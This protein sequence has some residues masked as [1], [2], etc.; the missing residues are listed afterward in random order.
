[1]ADPGRPRGS[2]LN[3]PVYP[4]LPIDR[5]PGLILTVQTWRLFRLEAAPFTEWSWA[6]FADP[7]CRF[8]SI[9]GS[10]RVRYAASTETG[11]ARERDRDTGGWVPASH[12]D[13]YW[14]E[15]TGELDL[16]D[17]RSNEGID[18]RIST[19]YENHVRATCHLL[20]DRAPQLVG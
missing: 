4:P 15:L 1:V 14:I 9:T 19:G 2:A 17:L 6:A 5:P 12:A 13:H 8:D 18:A 20:T 11:A 16:L 10:H 7:Q 3:G